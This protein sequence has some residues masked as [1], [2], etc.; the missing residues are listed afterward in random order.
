MNVVVQL[1]QYRGIWIHCFL[2]PQTLHGLLLEGER[3]ISRTEAV[4]SVLFSWIGIWRWLKVLKFAPLTQI[5][6]SRPCCRTG[7]Q[8]L[9]QEYN[10]YLS[11]SLSTDVEAIRSRLL[12]LSVPILFFTFLSTPHNC[13]LALTRSSPNTTDTNVVCLLL[14]CSLSEFFCRTHVVV[15]E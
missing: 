5:H 3:G 1:Q 15:E 13:L 8:A 11:L 10:T 9:R 7:R 6:A 14:L 2:R 4:E 12:V